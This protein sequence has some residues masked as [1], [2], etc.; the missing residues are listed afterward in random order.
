MSRTLWKLEPVAKNAAQGACIFVA[1]VQVIA[2]SADMAS[3]PRSMK[4]ATPPLGHLVKEVRIPPIKVYGLDRTFLVI[5]KPPV[6]EYGLD[7]L[8]DLVGTPHF[9]H[10]R[11]HCVFA[12]AVVDL[13]I[14]KP[15]TPRDR[16]AALSTIV[17][18]YPTP[19]TTCASCK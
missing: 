17:D 8:V 4:I 13:Q 19:R 15:V 11:G 5:M 2:R 16:H 18:G 9:H 10:V 3:P 12:M 14:V 6:V 7:I 1:E